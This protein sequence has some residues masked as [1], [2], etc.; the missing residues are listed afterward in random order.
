MKDCNIGEREMICLIIVTVAVALLAI[1]LVPKTSFYY[2]RNRYAKFLKEQ[3]EDKAECKRKY[4]KDTLELV[5][6]YQYYVRLAREQR[7]LEREWKQQNENLGHHLWIWQ[8]SKATKLQLRYLLDKEEQETVPHAKVDVDFGTEPQEI[9][10][11]W[12]AYKGNCFMA[13][14][15][16]SG[17]MM[18]AALEFITRFRC[19]DNPAKVTVL[20]L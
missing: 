7:E 19:V 13:E 1:F 2:E 20:H 10:Y 12:T 17:Y 16:H 14:L 8:R 3:M 11:Y 15:N 6:T 5:A 4:L 18:E 9:P